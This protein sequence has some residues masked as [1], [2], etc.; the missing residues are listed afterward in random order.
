MEIKKENLN[1]N[2]GY[3]YTVK[4]KI[5]SQKSKYQDLEIILTEEF[6]KVLLLDGI[7]QVGE[8]DHFQY[9]EL[10]THPN[11]LTIK[12]PKDVLVVGGGDGGVNREVLKHPSIKKLDHVELDGDVIL[13][14]K[15]HLASISDGAFEDERVNVVIEDGRSFLENNNHLYDSIIMDLTDPFGPALKLYTQDFFNIVKKSLKENGKFSMHVESPTSQPQLF[16]QIINTLRS[17]FSQVNI[18][19]NY[20]KMYGC[21]WAV[22][23]CSLERNN[24]IFLGNNIDQILEDKGIANLNLINQKTFQSM[25]SSF[26]YIENLLKENNV[27]LTDDRVSNLQSTNN[28]LM[29]YE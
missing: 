7:T 18:F 14:S 5:V 28:G 12:E 22:A 19:Y 16:S 4:E 6:G 26:P 15:Q 3:F 23:V 13:F 21:L 29:T 1:S 27:I 8:K 2:Y 20:I 24:D 25:Q 17:V 10:I 9:H 11:L